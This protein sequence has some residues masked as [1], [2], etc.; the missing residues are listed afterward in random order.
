MRGI[1]VGQKCHPRRKY[2]FLGKYCIVLGTKILACAH[3]WFPYVKYWGEYNYC[4]HSYQRNSYPFFQGWRN[5]LDK[6][7]I[8]QN[9][10]W[11]SII[12]SGGLKQLLSLRLLIIIWKGAFSCNRIPQLNTAAISDYHYM[13]PFYT[14]I[15]VNNIYRS[16]ILFL[17]LF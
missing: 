17:K 5:F 7:T 1:P 3:L 10:D 11:C 15:E 9:N 13:L 2:L 4:Q 6:K 16:L 12:E 14:I 8:K